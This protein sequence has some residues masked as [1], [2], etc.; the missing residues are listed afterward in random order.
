MSG[1]VQIYVSL[2]GEGVDVWRPVQ[3]EHVHGDRYRIV[4]QP[5]D[6]AIETWQFEPGDE[7]TCEMV[8]A[9]DGLVLGATRKAD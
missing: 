9:S 6:R 4:S 1:V 2:L 5:Y 3:A 7:V 8:K